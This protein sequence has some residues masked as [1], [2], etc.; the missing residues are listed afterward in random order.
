M[1]KAHFAP[2]EHEG[3]EPLNLGFDVNVAGSAIGAPGSY[4][5]EQG[6]GIHSKNPLARPVPDLDQYHGSDTYLTEALTLEAKVEVDKA[7]AKEKPFFL[8]MSHYAVH[9]PFNSDPRFAANYQ[10][11]SKRRPYL[12]YATMIEGMDKSL[13]DLM[14]HL[15]AKGVAENTLIL[16]LG[17][18]GGDAPVEDVDAI[19]ASAPAWAQGRQVGRRD[20]CTLYGCL[21][22]NGYRKCMAA[23]T[24]HTG[25]ERA[26][27]DR[28]LLRPVSN[29]SGPCRSIRSR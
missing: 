25:W 6:Y 24:A 4:Y 5:G 21:G 26:P 28:K 12:A 2:F 27:G 8:H 9:S 18:N 19:D 13:G 23:E 29:H 15:E 3:E 17:D 1:G 10:D 20:A 14:D 11:D 22:K 16:F 7:I